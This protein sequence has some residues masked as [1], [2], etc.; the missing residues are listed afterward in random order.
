MTMHCSAMLARTGF[1][2]LLGLSG[3]GKTTLSADP[4]RFRS[5][6]M[7]T[8]GTMTAFSTLKGVATPRRSTSP[9]R[10]SPRYVAIRTDALLENVAVDKDGNVDYFDTSK[11]QNGRVSYPIITL[12]TGTSRRWRGTRT[13]SSSDAMP[14]ASFPQ[15]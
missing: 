4:E 14:L 6:T 12:R 10:T 8:A 5:A 7:S 15:C 1:G 2:I 11:T 13:V 3:T 9:R